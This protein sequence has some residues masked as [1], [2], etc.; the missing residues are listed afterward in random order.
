MAFN[1]RIRLPFKLTRPQFPE[2]RNVF[3]KANGEVKVLSVI[4]RKTYQG[5]TDW[6]PEKWHQRLRLALAHDHVVYEGEK[7]VGE[8]S[9]DGEYAIE[10]QEERDYPTA[11]AAFQVQVT[12]FDATN[13]N[14]KMLAEVVQL[15]LVDDTFPEPL[16]ENTEYSIML[17]DNDSV[18]CFPAV[19][20][21]TDYNA[22]YIAGYNI[23]QETGELM[24]F[25]K[26]GLVS[27]NGLKLMTYR[28]TCPNGGYDEANVFGNVEGTI[29]GC[30][31]PLDLVLQSASPTELTFAWTPP[32]PSPANGYD[33]DIRKSSA[34]G[35]V[36][37]SGIERPLAD[38][39][40]ASLEPNTQYIFQVRGNCGDGSYSN[41]INITAST[42]PFAG[43]CGQYRLN[44][45]N[46]S[47]I[48]SQFGNIAV[49]ECDG[50]VRPHLV[51]N[52]QSKFVCALQSAPG[53]PVQ[54]TGPAG[55]SVNYLGLC[56]EG[57]YT[58]TTV[59]VSSEGGGPGICA[60]PP[61]DAYFLAPDSMIEPGVVIYSAPGVPLTGYD[62]IRDGFGGGIHIL[63]PGSGEV[64]ALTGD[65][66]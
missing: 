39:I 5:E 13:T 29:E 24:I 41:Y 47:G 35:V 63:N 3:R 66:C 50:V 51:Y 30:L 61:L 17:S 2:E 37:Q 21:V 6:F 15:N 46:G 65:I 31:A 40:I 38:I 32:T 20:S 11:K 62:Q 16:Q 14:C 1:N 22:D 52:M 7:Y 44:Y 58:A 60:A 56:G 4:V 19:F 26:T 34:P 33:W 42:T 36:V 25:M 59:Y 57:T 18:C 49:R 28:V 9:G 64:G 27:A 43:T 8:I 23:V 54:I 53:S 10:W 12:P 45:N 48:P 55:T